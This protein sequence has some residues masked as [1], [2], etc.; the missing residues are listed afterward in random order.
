MLLLWLTELLLLLLWHPS[1]EHSCLLLSVVRLMLAE[2]LLR[3]LLERVQR[4]P[5]T[6]LLVRGGGHLRLHWL[7]LLGLVYRLLGRRGHASKVLSRPGRH[8][9]ASTRL[10]ER[11]WVELRLLLLLLGLVEGRLLGGR[12]GLSGRERHEVAPGAVLGDLRLL[13]LLHCTVS[14]LRLEG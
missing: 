12:L 3:L 1:S 13:H 2:L 4:R 11:R 5:L 7:L 14:I 10:L 9:C 6:E 8:R